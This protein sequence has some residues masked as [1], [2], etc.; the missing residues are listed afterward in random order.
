MVNKKLFI[1]IIFFLL[2]LVLL[3]KFLAPS[4]SIK[5]ASHEILTKKTYSISFIHLKNT[6]SVFIY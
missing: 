6:F 1:T 5:K 2:S 4:Q 3:L